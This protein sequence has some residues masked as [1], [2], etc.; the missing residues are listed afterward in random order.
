MMTGYG[1]A[2]DLGGWLWMIL[3]LAID[4]GGR[5]AGYGRPTE[6]AAPDRRGRHSDPE[7]EGSP[8]ARS[9]NMNTNRRVACLGSVEQPRNTR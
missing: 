7:G 3:A 6:T 5:V 8:V 4:R 1:W 2:I 9:P